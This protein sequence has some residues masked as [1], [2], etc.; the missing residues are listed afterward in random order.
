LSLLRAPALLGSPQV[1]YLCFEGVLA[2]LQE[3]QLFLHQV[4]AIHLRWLLF[5]LVELTSQRAYRIG[6]MTESLP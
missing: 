3:L 4:V 2:A 6:V 1:S 5:E